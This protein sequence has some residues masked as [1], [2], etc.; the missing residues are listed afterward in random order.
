[1]GLK[2]ISALGFDWRHVAAVLGRHEVSELA[3][4]ASNVGHERVRRAL[5]EL[6]GLARR[7]GIS[8]SVV[9]VPSEDVWSC[10][11]TALGHFAGAQVVLDLGGGVRSVGTCLLLAALLAEELLEARVVKAYTQAE[12]KEAVVPFDLC[13]L[14]FAQGLRGLKATRRRAALLGREAGE[15]RYSRDLL[16]EMAECGLLKDGGGLTP[17]GEALKRALELSS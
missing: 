7:M 12:D 4:F 10:V 1:M 17:A 2:Q 15:D 9:E 6:G 16:R 5:E 8:M 3:L 13:P 11:S 14:R